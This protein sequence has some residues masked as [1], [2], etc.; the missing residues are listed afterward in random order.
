MNFCT[1]WAGTVDVFDVADGFDACRYMDVYDDRSTVKR[2]EGDSDWCCIAAAMV[3]AATF[4]SSH[5]AR[6]V[7]V[8]TPP[9]ELRSNPV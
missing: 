6:R 9:L 2:I 8:W 5:L 7:E 3:V 4:V 1:F